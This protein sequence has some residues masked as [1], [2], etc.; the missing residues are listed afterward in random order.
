MPEILEMLS[1]LRLGPKKTP[2]DI[3]I[4]LEEIQA[5]INDLIRAT[6]QI[7]ERLNASAES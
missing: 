5:K 7:S 4:A 3:E 2:R 1:E 6:N